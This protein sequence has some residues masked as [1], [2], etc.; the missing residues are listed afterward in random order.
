MWLTAPKVSFTNFTACQS[1][2]SGRNYQNPKQHII[3]WYM[4]YMTG[5]Q[6]R[7]DA[8]NHCQTSICQ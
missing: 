2:E 4:F 5:E 3:V 7:E 6:S 8:E 1:K